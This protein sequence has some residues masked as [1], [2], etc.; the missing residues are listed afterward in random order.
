MARHKSCVNAGRAVYLSFVVWSVS[1]SVAPAL[2]LALAPTQTQTQI[3]ASNSDSD[4]DSASDDS[5]LSFC[6]MVARK[7]SPRLSSAWSQSQ[8]A[9]FITHKADTFVIV[10]VVVVLHNNKCVA[11]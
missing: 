6:W 2:A 5:M 10:V 11:C 3:P 8:Q 9:H 7:M 4:S 1:V